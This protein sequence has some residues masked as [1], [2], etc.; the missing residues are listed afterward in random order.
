MQAQVTQSLALRA[1]NGNK[2]STVS[3]S[4]RRQRQLR[5]SL[6][7]KIVLSFC[8]HSL[9]FRILASKRRDAITGSSLPA[10]E[11]FMTSSCMHRL[12]RIVIICFTASSLSVLTTSAE[13]HV[14]AD[15]VNAANRFLKSL[16]EEQRTKVAIPFEGE[17]RTAWHFIPSSMM[18]ARGGRRGLA[19]KEMSPDQTAL[20]YGLLNT[21]LSHKGHLQATTIM[22]LEAILRDI[23]NGNPARDPAMYHVAIYGSP[24]ADQTWGWSVEGHHL[25]LNI[26]LIN[27][28]DFSVTPSFFG[29]NPAIVKSGPF[30]G[31]D[32]LAAEQRIARQ[33]IRSLSEEQQKKAIIDTKAPRDVITG[34]ERRVDRDQFDPPQGISFE[35]LTDGQQKTLITLVHQFSN[36]Y[37]TPILEQIQDRAPIDDGKGMYFAWAGSTKPGEGHY[38]RIQTPHYLFEYDNTQNGANHVHAVWRTFDGDFGEDLLRRH[39]ETSSHHNN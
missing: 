32:T 1:C 6:E 19:M 2:S 31:L 26:M 39:Y 12:N 5:L 10:S 7:L 9:V 8:S 28:T 38:Y 14:P 34:A 18:D 3:L 25:S 33:L 24:S 17:K 23:E 4:S 21:A 27:G 20:A 37:R 35:Q 29:S 36:K 16:Q 22:A 11:F 15:M 30:E 13:A